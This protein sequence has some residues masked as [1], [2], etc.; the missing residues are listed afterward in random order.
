M[1]HI[2]ASVNWV[3][4]GLGNGLSPVRCQAITWT[5]ADLLSIEPL[6]TNFSE[7]RIEMQKKNHENSFENVVYKMAAILLRENEFN[8]AKLHQIS[9]LSIS[10]F[11]WC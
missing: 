9:H 11:S 1:P 3:S 5:N 4:T 7:S 6:G 10:I 2:Y 8:Y